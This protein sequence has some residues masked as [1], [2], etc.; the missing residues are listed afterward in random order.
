[1]YQDKWPLTG[2][3]DSWPYCFWLSAAKHV[4]V[5]YVWE[6]GGCAPSLWSTS[7]ERCDLLEFYTGGLCPAWAVNET[8]T[9]FC[10]MHRVSSES[11]PAPLTPASR[12]RVTA[13]CFETARRSIPTY[14]MLNFSLIW[15]W[16]Q[17]IRDAELAFDVEM[18]QQRCYFMPNLVIVKRDLK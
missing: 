11:K 3:A 8:F 4:C 1:M 2:Q 7:Q 6:R 12:M 13:H 10:Q 5:Y 18:G 15:V 9:L 14:L 16:G 17:C